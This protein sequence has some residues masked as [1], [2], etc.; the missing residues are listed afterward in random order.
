[1]LNEEILECLKADI[2]LREC[3]IISF[4]MY[5]IA[6]R[7]EKHRFSLKFVK[8]LILDKSHPTALSDTTQLL[9]RTFRAVA[10]TA[11]PPL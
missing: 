10:A 7:F 6:Y 8:N 11:L 3:L 1:M 2:K 4:Q 9:I 5:L